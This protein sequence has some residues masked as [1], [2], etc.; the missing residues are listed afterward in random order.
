MDNGARRNCI[1]SFNPSRHTVLD[2]GYRSQWCRIVIEQERL[3]A[4]EV[5]SGKWKWGLGWQD[6]A[7]RTCLL[8]R[9]QVSFVIGMGSSNAGSKGFSA[10]VRVG[11]M[12]IGRVLTRRSLGIAPSEDLTVVCELDST[13]ACHEKL[14]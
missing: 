2:I 7:R 8:L 5:K 12:C 4:I 11:E 6:M 3:G 13:S 14:H 10:E 1:K 9:L